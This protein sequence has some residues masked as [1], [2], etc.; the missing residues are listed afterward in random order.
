MTEDNEMSDILIL[1]LGCI[2]INATLF[3]QQKL[4]HFLMPINQILL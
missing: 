2:M 4:H 3:V 1:S